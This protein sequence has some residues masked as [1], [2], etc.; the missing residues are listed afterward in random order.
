LVAFKPRPRGTGIG[1][2]GSP[3]A[4]DHSLATDGARI[5]VAAAEKRGVY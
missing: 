5:A 3:R 4:F 1:S 2:R